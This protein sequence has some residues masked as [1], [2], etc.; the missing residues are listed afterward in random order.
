M[1]A[2]TKPATSNTVD[3]SAPLRITGVANIDPVIGSYPVTVT[4]RLNRAPTEYEAVA[5]QIYTS[6]KLTAGLDS[7][8]IRTTTDRV[9]A[10][11]AAAA[12]GIKTVGVESGNLQNRRETTISQIE[13]DLEE[14][15]S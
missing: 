4:F 10:D 12:T 14:L 9:K 11:A 1:S 2:P 15:F 13:A 5:S 8:E 3:T 6:I 7:F